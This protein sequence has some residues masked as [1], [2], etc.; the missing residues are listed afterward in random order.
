MWWHLKLPKLNCYFQ[1][2]N[3]IV[4]PFSRHSGCQ[5]SLL[6]SLIVDL[7]FSSKAWKGTGVGKW[8]VVVCSCGK[9]LHDYAGLW[10]SYIIFSAI[11]L[12]KHRILT[13]LWI[14][15]TLCLMCLLTPLLLAVKI[16]SRTVGQSVFSGG[17][18]KYTKIKANP[19]ILL[20]P[21]FCPNAHYQTFSTM[22]KTILCVKSHFWKSRISQFTRQS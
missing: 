11:F 8:F 19:L 13:V 16:S 9:I 2:A 7:G 3:S 10:P 12:W 15:A 1:I 6:H 17:Y 22:P 5:W 14:K 20:I 4:L 21:P 18:I